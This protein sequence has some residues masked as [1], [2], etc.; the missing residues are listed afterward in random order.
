LSSKK[1][2]QLVRQVG[3]ASSI[4]ADSMVVVFKSVIPFSLGAV[5]C[6]G[7]ISCI[8]DVEG[9]LHHLVISPERKSPSGSL[10]EVAARPQTVPTKTPTMT[11][12]GMVPHEARLR[13]P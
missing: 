8:V 13:I 12:Q 9:I 1:H 5:F 3:V 7:T 11:R 2:Q 6:F 10:K 4:N